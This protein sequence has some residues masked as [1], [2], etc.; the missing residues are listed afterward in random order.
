LLVDFLRQLP[1]VF[2]ERYLQTHSVYL[3]SI[4]DIIA[5]MYKTRNL[6]KASVNMVRKLLTQGA[7]V[8]EKRE[9]PGHETLEFRNLRNC[10]YHECS[11]NYPFK[12][13]DERLKFAS[14]K[15]IQCYY[16]VFASIAALVC[17]YHPPQKSPIKTLNIYGREFLCSKER[18]N[19]FLPPVNLYLNQQG[20]IPI[21]LSE[22]ISWGYA[23]EFKMPYIKK[24]L[25]S[26]HKENTI[27][28]I[29]H[30]LKSLREWVTYQDAYLLFRLYGEAPKEDLDFSLKK[31]AFVH[32]LQTEYYL[33]NLFGWDAV[34]R[35][36]DT[37]LTELENNLGITSSTLLGR[38]DAYRSFELRRRS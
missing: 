7:K 22:R 24:C 8:D 16:S 18:R 25:E 35:Q 28:T 36:Y 6:R 21:D 15:I 13:L 14:W 30:Y 1:E 4:A 31:I 11:L 19:F 33:I 10:W 38:F 9:D 29:P 32:C 3:K 5:A 37:F 12:N 20:I 27:T 17:C 34:E 2:R 23:H 26:V